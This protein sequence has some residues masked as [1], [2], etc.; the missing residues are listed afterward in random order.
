VVALPT[1]NHMRARPQTCPRG[2]AFVVGVFDAA[3]GIRYTSPV[4]PALDNCPAG[5]LGNRLC[6]R[7]DGE[8]QIGAEMRCEYGEKDTSANNSGGNHER[9][10]FEISPDCLRKVSAGPFLA[11]FTDGQK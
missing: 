8:C 3:F 11:D 1:T 10:H 9:G 7:K 4:V 5:P 2:R 6:T